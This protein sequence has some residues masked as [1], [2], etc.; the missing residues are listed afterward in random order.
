MGL[1]DWIVDGAIRISLGYDN[2]EEEIDYF[3]E[4]LQREINRLR[5]LS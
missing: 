1:E 3:V 2:S 4:V 5:S